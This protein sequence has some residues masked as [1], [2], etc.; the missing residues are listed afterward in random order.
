MLS[1]IAHELFWL[2]RDL[3]RGEHTARMLDGAFHA[4]VAGSS[5]GQAIALSWD[6]V[7][8]IIGAK[9][10]APPEGAVDSA[11]HLESS[12]S[13]AVQDDGEAAELPQTRTG[14][15]RLLSLDLESPASITSCVSRARERGHTLRDVI[16]TEMWEALNG[17]HLSLA[18]H[19][20][21]TLLQTGPYSFYQEVKA[22]CA[23]FWGVTDRTMLRDESR[24]FLEAGRRV[25]EADMV[26]RMLRV[27]VPPESADGP[28]ASEAVALLHAVGGAQAF[29]RAT[30]STPTV[31]AVVCFLLYDSSYPAS[32]AA[33]VGALRDALLIADLQPRVSP[34]VLRLER[35]VAELELQ[36]RTPGTPSGLDKTLERVQE[37]LAL[38]DADIGDRYFALALAAMG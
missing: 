34:P 37:E 17:F 15:A 21:A 11:P 7:L 27:A 24:A 25:E 8:A 9:T 31:T 29:R 33:A 12:L 16:S 6:A 28:H 19:D 32:V 18:D 1:R 35:L 26:L 13:V 10:P 5:G 22:R 2:G 4:D 23:L 20:T 14:I 38:I 3:T 36:R 30:R